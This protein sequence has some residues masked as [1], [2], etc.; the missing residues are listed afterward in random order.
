MATQILKADLEEKCNEYE[1]LMVEVVGEIDDTDDNRIEMR[2]C[3][4][5]IRNKIENVYGD[6]LTDDVNEYLGI[7][8]EDDSEDFDEDDESN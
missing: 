6:S 8:T 7:E 1:T 2:Q 3:L 5:D 4:E